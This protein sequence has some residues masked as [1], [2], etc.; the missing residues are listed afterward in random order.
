[1][2]KSLTPAKNSGIVTKKKFVKGVTMFSVMKVGMPARV[3]PMA[4]MTSARNVEMPVTPAEIKSKTGVTTVS[5]K[6]SIADTMKVL[7]PSSREAS[8]SRSCP[9]GS[10]TPAV[11]LERISRFMVSSI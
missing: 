1:V 5:M 8:H 3:A 11:Q 4:G 6:L 9:M 7:T 2:K 10:R